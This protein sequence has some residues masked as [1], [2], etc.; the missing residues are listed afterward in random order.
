MQTD[1]LDGFC[2]L[3]PDPS[4]DGCHQV[5]SPPIVNKPQP[6]RCSPRSKDRYSCLRQGRPGHSRMLSLPV[7]ILPLQ[8]SGRDRG[9]D[10]I[11]GKNRGE[12][13]GSAGLTEAY[14]RPST[15]A[16]ITNPCFEEEHPHSRMFVSLC[17]RHCPRALGCSLLTGSLKILLSIHGEIEGHWAEVLNRSTN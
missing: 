13:E 7:C 15:H 16:L 6:G 3:C 8:N 4:S 9:W 17:A 5:I 2:I 10:M 1:S 14:R 11:R 12:D